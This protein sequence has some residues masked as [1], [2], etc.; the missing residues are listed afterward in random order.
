MDFMQYFIK[1]FSIFFG[2]DIVQE[3]LQ[4]V[5]SASIPEGGMRLLL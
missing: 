4:A 2:D 3:V 5:N 1:D